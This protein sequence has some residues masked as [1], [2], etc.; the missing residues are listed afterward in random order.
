MSWYEIKTSQTTQ[1]WK[2]IVRESSSL[3]QNTIEM[4]ALISIGL[5]SDTQ[6]SQVGLSYTVLQ[7][8]FCTHSWT[9]WAGYKKATL[10]VFQWLFFKTYSKIF[11][12]TTRLGVLG[13]GVMT[14]NIIW[15][16]LWRLSKVILQRDCKWH[17]I[18]LRTN[19]IFFFYKKQLSS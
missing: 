7:S 6:H 9:A 2:W 18:C 3:P 5:V 4:T 17:G 19:K 14:V 12:P 8:W 11:Y 1:L 16:I 13:K 10:T 15:W